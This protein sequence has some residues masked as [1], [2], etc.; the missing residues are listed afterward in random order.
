MFGKK[1]HKRSND[2]FIISKGIDAGN[3]KGNGTA[4][5]TAPS[6]KGT[7]LKIP[8]GGMYTEKN[9]RTDYGQINKGKV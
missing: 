8:G 3:L 9:R 4:P 7:S 6:H 5:K 1:R 2:A